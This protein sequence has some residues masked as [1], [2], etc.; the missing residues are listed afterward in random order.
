MDGVLNAGET[1]T[2]N[3]WPGQGILL[4][5]TSALA[6]YFSGSVASLQIYDGA[7]SA[8]DVTSLANT[9]MPAPIVDLDA[10]LL[11]PGALATWT[12]NG[13][14]GGSFGKDTTNPSMQ[15]VSGRPAVVFGGADRM[16]EHIHVPN[17]HF[18]QR[19]LDIRGVGA[20]PRDCGG[21][22]RVHVV[23]SGHERTRRS[24]ELWQQH[25]LRRG[26]ALQ[27]GH[28]LRWWYSQRQ[29][30]ALHSRDVQRHDGE[31]V[32]GWTTERN[33][34]ENTEHICRGSDVCRLREF[35]HSPTKYFSGSVALLRM[36]DRALSAS[37]ILT[38]SSGQADLCV[39]D[40][41]SIA[42]GTMVTLKSKT[43]TLAP[44]DDAGNR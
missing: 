20:E 17:Q 44:R 35:R 15:V 14:L 36:Y 9:W 13:T 40:L 37:D 38:L 22:V 34:G 11:A 33:G 1:K 5:C 8:T 25:E 26:C 2:L 16:K 18:R 43:V 24:D 31:R 7:L 42:D 32:C 30:L 29:R 21:G 12:N 41:K 39:G 28:G 3:I 6:D 23:A 27:P 19:K 4:G 10:S